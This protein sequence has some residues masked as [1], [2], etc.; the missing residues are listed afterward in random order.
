MYISN[1]CD[2]NKIF[3][4]YKTKNSLGKYIKKLL[5][6]PW[7]YIKERLKKSFNLCIREKIIYTCTLR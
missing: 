2:I 4:N 5:G 6:I 1:V 7:L 3:L